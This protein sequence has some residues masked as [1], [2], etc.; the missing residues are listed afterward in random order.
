METLLSWQKGLKNILN[1]VN[2][3]EA[4]NPDVQLFNIH[5]DAEVL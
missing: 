3:E 1:N 2:E 5:P 4:P